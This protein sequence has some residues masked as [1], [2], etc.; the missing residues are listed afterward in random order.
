[1]HS[2]SATGGT[3]HSSR[4]KKRPKRKVRVEEKRK[5]II[6]QTS[7]RGNL[8]KISPL[9][10]RGGGNAGWKSVSRER[11]E[12]RRDMGVWVA[13]GV[14]DGGMNRHTRRVERMKRYYREKEKRLGLLR[15]R[16][17]GGPTKGGV[18]LSRALT[19]QKRQT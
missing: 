16:G 19:Q 9:R 13:A 18:F 2:L 8:G 1:V 14:R 12:C 3:R 6:G 15:R 17:R 7:Y 5:G 4:A 10:K 11:E